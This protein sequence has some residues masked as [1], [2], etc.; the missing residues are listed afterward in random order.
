MA[1]QQM[2]YGEAV[3]ALKGMKNLSRKV[4]GAY[5]TYFKKLGDDL[6]SVSEYATSLADHVPGVSKALGKISEDYRKFGEKLSREKDPQVIAVL[7]QQYSRI[8]EIINA[9]YHNLSDQLKVKK[10]GKE[11][12]NA[13]RATAGEIATLKDKID[14]SID[15]LESNIDQVEK[16]Y[17][18]KKKQSKGEI[19]ETTYH[20]P[21]EQAEA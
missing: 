5:G 7:S 3:K 13:T 6:E 17:E 15:G 8:G 20:Q 9:F 18:A 11:L 1:Q 14:S 2:D 21:R 19:V 12:A 16:A 10:A 4:G